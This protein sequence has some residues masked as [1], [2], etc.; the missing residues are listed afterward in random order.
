MKLDARQ[1][2]GFL[3]DP[4]SVRLVLLHGDDEGMIREHA[5]T[6]TKGVTGNPNDPF[7]VTELSR[8]S[9]A[10]IPA[11]MA[12]LSMIGGRR[13]V[14]VR[15]GTDAVL[16]PVAEA[17]K[18]PGQALLVVEAP[19]LGKGKLRSFAEAGRDAAVIG[20]YPEEGQ[21]LADF[22][23]ISL[24]AAGLD[25]DADALSFLAA[26]LGGDRATVRAEIEKLALFA[27]PGR[28]LDG[29]TARACVGEASR[30]AGDDALLHA[31]Q[32]DT[33][34]ADAA[35]EAAVGDGLTGVAL[36]RMAVS[37]L[38][39]LHQARLRVE[40]G[41]RAAEVVRAMRPPVFYKSI[42]AMTAAVNLWPADALLRAIEEARQVE[43]ACKT[44]GSPQELLA[45]RFISAL[46]RQAGRLGAPR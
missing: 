9:W 18:G 12:A 6:L 24:V 16:A 44:T 42:P 10:R 15:E 39:R 14:R 43:L 30:R 19:G 32:G 33:Q 37:H 34:R 31:M 41:A 13:V 7:L 45:R 8:E 11:E 20:C 1:V 40:S 5:Q 21:A 27:G 23:R 46:T 26:S 2:A 17:M 35:L 38:Q 4:G 36:L 25:A 22:I 3:R 29:E 28:R